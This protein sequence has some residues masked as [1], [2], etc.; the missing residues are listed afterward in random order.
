MII[1]ITRAECF[2]P[3]SVDRDRAIMEA[4]IRRLG[5]IMVSEDS[6][7]ETMPVDVSLCV[8]MARRPH[9][10][11]M[12][13][14]WEACGVTIVNP[15]GGVEMCARSRLETLMRQEGIP[16]PPQTGD[17]GCWI[18]RGDAAAQSACDV[19]YCHD[20]AELTAAKAQF[21]AR[22]VTDYVVSAHIR[23]DLVKFYGVEGTGFFRFFYPGDDGI[24]KF[25]DEKRN[26]RPCHHA[27]SDTRLRNEAERLARLVHTPIYGGDAV[28]APDGAFYIIDFNDWPS[29]S[30]CREDAADAIAE[31]AIHYIGNGKQN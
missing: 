17:A 25:G 27:F 31:L 24:S 12:L 14:R 26:G 6:L 23:G 3:N 28:I 10:L 7:S 13:R 18:K 21:A 1:G 20:D 15:P 16:M 11:T 9:T 2:S 22:G 30:R 5:G 19:V 29:Y 8:S 4:V